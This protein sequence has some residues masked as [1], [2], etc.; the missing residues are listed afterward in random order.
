MP[1]GRVDHFKAYSDRSSA[2]R[3]IDV[4][5]GEPLLST[6]KGFR[7]P[8][9]RVGDLETQILLKTTF[10]PTWPAMKE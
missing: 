3:K 1:S 2:H 4:D 6:A 7:L 8:D 5:A 9:R 10:G